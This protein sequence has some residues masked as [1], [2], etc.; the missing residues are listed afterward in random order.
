MPKNSYMQVIAKNI[1]AAKQKVRDECWQKTGQIVDLLMIAVTVHLNDKCGLGKERIMRV[2]EAM[3]E[4]LSTFTKCDDKGYFLHD[5]K[6]DYK[7]IM[8]TEYDDMPG[9]EME[10]DW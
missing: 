10:V 1:E 8:G 7:R 9:V 5:L 3:S 6:R 4:T 2:N